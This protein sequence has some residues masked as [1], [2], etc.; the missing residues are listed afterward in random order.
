MR[1]SST[2]RVHSSGLIASQC[3]GTWTSL[4]TCPMYHFVSRRRRGEVSSG[5]RPLRVHC[6]TTC[7]PCQEQAIS[8]SSQQ[9]GAAACRDDGK[10][11]GSGAVVS[12]TREKWPESGNSWRPSHHQRTGSASGDRGRGD[13]GALGRRELVPELAKIA[14]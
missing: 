12:T 1:M 3:S 8:S 6:L 7:L 4:T 11:W 13:I 9:H 5:F 2:T 10:V 14:P